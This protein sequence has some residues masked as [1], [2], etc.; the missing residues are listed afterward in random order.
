MFQYKKYLIK[1]TDQFD[2]EYY[3]FVADELE[4][5]IDQTEHVA[6]SFKAE[7]IVYFLK[8]L[9]LKDEWIAANPEL[10]RLV[11]SKTL[12]AGNIRAL[13]ESC[14]NN[15]VFGQQLEAYLKRKIIEKYIPVAG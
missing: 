8:D 1:N 2:P 4:V 9:S 11:T 3:S 5:M 10:A 7:I 6:S 15:P 13:F 12:S 14:H